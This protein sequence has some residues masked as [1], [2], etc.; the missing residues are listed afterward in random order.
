MGSI[1]ELKRQDG[2]TRYHAEVRVRGVPPQRS[3]FRTKAQAKHWIQQMEQEIGEGRRP[4]AM[5]ARR[6]TVGDLIDRFTDEVLTRFPHRKKQQTG[7]LAWWKQRHETLPLDQL[8]PAVLCRARNE[9]KDQETVRGPC[10]EPATV[11][12]YLAALGSALSIAVREWEW[13]ESSP[14]KRVTKLRESQGRDRYL[15]FE[16]KDRLLEACK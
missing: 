1:R 2:T 9:L 13:M 12:R 10:R 15:S 16:E 7:L 11:N 4:L 14:M 6:H 3:S 5:E 8:T